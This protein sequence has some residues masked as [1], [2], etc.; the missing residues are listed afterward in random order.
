MERRRKAAEPL[1][2]IR[3]SRFIMVIDAT[4]CINCK[5]CVLACQQRN[6]VPYT[7]SR[8][9][10]REAPDNLSPLGTAYQPGA[11]MHCDHPLCVD[12]CPTRATYKADDG[13]VV[14]DRDRCIGCGGW[15]GGRPSQG[16]P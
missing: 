8:N 11:C 14:I 16:N 10:I 13:S 1:W 4:K 12:A 9:W 7:H 5:A 2:R 6:G 3:M 15:F